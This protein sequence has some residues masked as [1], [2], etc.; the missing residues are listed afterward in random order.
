MLV[1]GYR[2]H[3]VAAGQH[4]SSDFPRCSAAFQRGE[5][6]RSLNTQ[7]S[8]SFRSCPR[9]HLF[10]SLASGQGVNGVN[11]RTDEPGRGLAGQDYGGLRI[12]PARNR[13]SPS[14]FL[15]RILLGNVILQYLMRAN[16]ALVNVGSVLHARHL[17]GCERVPSSSNSSTLSESAPWTL[18]DPS[19]SRD[20]PE[21]APDPSRE[22]AT[23]STLSLLALTRFLSAAAI[24]APTVFW[25]TTGSGDSDR[26]RTIPLGLLRGPEH[27]RCLH[28]VARRRTGWDKMQK[29]DRS[30]VK[31]TTHYGLWKHAGKRL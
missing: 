12:L 30:A 16:L 22:N 10:D 1:V 14:L 15:I 2:P 7:L 5:S 21:P 13:A 31:R 29:I 27:L 20:W 9:Y 11:R 26:W 6:G 17:V 3:L 4:P 25:P 19:R 23:V 8:R 28:E 18:D 24:F